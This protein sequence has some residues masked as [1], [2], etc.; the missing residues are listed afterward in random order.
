MARRWLDTCLSDHTCIKNDAPNQRP[1]RLLDLQGSDIAKQAKL[2]ITAT[3]T[4]SNAPYI[5]LSHCWGAA[6]T[7]KLLIGNE[8]D[9]RS[10]FPIDSLPT[11]YKDAIQIT[12]SLGIRYLWIDSLCIIQDSSD[13]WLREA[14]MMDTV[15]A[16][17]FCNIAALDAA[18]SNGGCFF[19]RDPTQVGIDTVEVHHPAEGMSQRYRVLI[20]ANWDEALGRSPLYNRAW[21]LQERALPPRTLLYGRK[22]IYWECRNHA[23]SEGFPNGLPERLKP[24]ATVALKQMPGRFHTNCSNGNIWDY[25]VEHY[26]RGNLTHLGDKLVAISGLACIYGPPAEGYL[27][28]VWRGTLLKDLL[29]QVGELKQSNGDPSFRP[30]DYRAPSWSWASVEGDINYTHRHTEHIIARVIE[31]Q[32]TPLVPRAEFGKVTAGH[33]R[34]SGPFGQADLVRHKENKQLFFQMRNIMSLCED[35]NPSILDVLQ[36]TLCAAFVWLDEYQGSRPPLTTIYWVLISTSKGLALSPSSQAGSYQRIGMFAALQ[37]PNPALFN[38]P[39][40]T[41]SIV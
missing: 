17:S 5:T 40:A 25:L 2:V 18:D 3:T 1:T 33:V 41:I 13:D 37:D 30:R 7:I 32:T 16:R 22:Q 34:I 38:Y 14:A 39:F 21:V 8:K 28:G 9:L 6:K 24:H 20:E 35:A 10:G 11:T 4:L 36:Q 26:S 12:R 23:A 19:E 27:A 31:A 29:W 15:Y